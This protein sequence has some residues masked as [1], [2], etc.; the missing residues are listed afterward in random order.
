LKR[1]FKFLIFFFTYRF[2]AAASG[3]EEIVTDFVL[4]LR[5][6]HM[7]DT[8]KVKIGGVFPTMR[9]RIPP[10]LCILKGVAMGWY[11]SSAV[12]GDVRRKKIA[13]LRKADFVAE[14]LAQATTLGADTI[15]AMFCSTTHYH[16]HVTWRIE[17]VSK[18]DM[19]PFLKRIDS[20]KLSGFLQ[21]W[22][23]ML[24]FFFNT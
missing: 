8:T 18:G 13:N 14:L 19:D 3:K 12:T 9:I 2:L 17:H 21:R 20:Q 15:I 6:L 11:F 24:V 23:C 7:A 4:F 22:V 10:T 5:W 16:G 1:T